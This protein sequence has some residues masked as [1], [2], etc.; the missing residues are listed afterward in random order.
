VLDL[1]VL[2]VELVLDVDVQIARVLPV[3]AAAQTTFQLLALAD[4]NDVVQIEDGLLPM[5]VLVFG[6]WGEHA[7]ARTTYR[8]IG[9]CV[10]VEK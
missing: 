4:G 10:L 6:A 5:G 7:L 8:I 1:Q 9:S 2:P 3:R